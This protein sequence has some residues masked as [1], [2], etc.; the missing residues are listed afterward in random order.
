MNYQ[1]IFIIIMGALFI[2]LPLFDAQAEELSLIPEVWLS[3]N[4]FYQGDTFAVVVKNVE[5]EVSG[6]FNSKSL[7]FFENRK[8]K[9]KVALVGISVKTKP[10][11]YKLVVNV[12][13]KPIFEKDILVLEKNFL[14]TSL[15]TTSSLVQKGYTVKNI[16]DN[17]VNKENQILAEIFSKTTP[18]P[19][20]SQPFVLPVSNTYDV[21]SFGNINKSGNYQLQH[22]GVD[23]KASINTPVYS[24][25]SGKVVFAGTLPNCGKSIVIDHGLGIY[26][27]YAH[28]GYIDVQKGQMVRRKEIIGLSGNTG[29]S[30]GPHLHFSIKY[31]GDS[32]DPLRFIL[33]SFAL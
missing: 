12:S 5:G 30:L 10:G 4:I 11:N 28:L 24:T 31:Q 8:N 29:Y 23:L 7:Q 18:Q 13:K 27:L 21:G 20:F 2:F 1:N 19:Y 25:N 33:S 15:A 14:V 17:S 26:S 32:L 22:L 6:N 9:N 16:V 3:T